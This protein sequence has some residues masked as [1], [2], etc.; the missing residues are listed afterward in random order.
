MKALTWEEL[1]RIFDKETGGAAMTLSLDAVASW[2]ASRKDLFAIGQDG[3][4]YLRTE[5]TRDNQ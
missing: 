5:K 1:A 4:I 2:A 3:T